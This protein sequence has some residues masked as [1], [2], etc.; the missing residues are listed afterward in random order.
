MI[1]GEASDATETTD[2]EEA[3]V[4]PMYWDFGLARHVS[5]FTVHAVESDRRLL[6]GRVMDHNFEN[7]VN[8]PS[9]Y[10]VCRVCRAR[11]RGR[12]EAARQSPPAERRM[13]PNSLDADGGGSEDEYGET[14]PYTPES[15]S[16][17]AE[18]EY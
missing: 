14:P 16:E 7:V 6:C 8:P 3:W 15:A 9:A 1:R 2:A 13:S 11:V 5:W 4:D 17:P 12:V 18:G 10:P